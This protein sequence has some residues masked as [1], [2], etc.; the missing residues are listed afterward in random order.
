MPP[1]E[2]T[3][4][5]IRIGVWNL[6]RSTM[7]SRRGA[8]QTDH[9]VAAEPDIWI[10]AEVPADLRTRKGQ[11]LVGNPRPREKAQC[12]TA[13]WSRWPLVPLRERH[14]SLQLAACRHPS[15]NI[16]VAASVLPWR[17]AG[18]DWPLDPDASYADRFSRCLEAHASEIRQA[19]HGYRLVW[20]GDFNQGLAGREHVGSL[21][22]RGRLLSTFDGLGLAPVTGNA[23][24]RRASEH[25]VD[26]VAVPDG[27]ALERLAVERP[28][29]DGAELSDHPAY[30][31]TLHATPPVRD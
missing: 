10:L 22:G 20:G 23:A 17:D 19:S 30:Q 31:V 18:A 24:G 11:L 13:I 25:A 2:D 14:P 21:S 9:L 7:Y 15:A 12:W 29:Q 8:L 1:R 6:G 28:R 27:W 26:H 5:E 16:L 4:F 3:S